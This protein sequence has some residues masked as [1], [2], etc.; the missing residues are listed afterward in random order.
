MSKSTENRYFGWKYIKDGSKFKYVSKYVGATGGEHWVIKPPNSS[1]KEYPT[2]REAAK[3]VDIFLINKGK[4]PV[5]ILK[6]K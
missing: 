1:S 2:E 4:E 6:R 3:A 5:N